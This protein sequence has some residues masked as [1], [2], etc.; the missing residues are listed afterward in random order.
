ML[1]LNLGECGCVK[2]TCGWFV[3]NLIGVCSELVGACPNLIL[4]VPFLYS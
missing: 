3:L 1:L 4:A 2:L